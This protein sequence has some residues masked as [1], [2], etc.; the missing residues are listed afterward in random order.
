MVAIDYRYRTNPQPHTGEVDDVA[1]QKFIVEQKK[2]KNYYSWVEQA[3]C[4]GKTSGENVRSSGYQESQEEQSL[5][6]PAEH[7]CKYFRI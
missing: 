7:V 5:S 1:V 4:V 2:L 3:T 6:W